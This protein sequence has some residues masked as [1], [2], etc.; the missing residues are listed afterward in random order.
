MFMTLVQTIMAV[1]FNNFFFLVVPC[2]NVWDSKPRFKFLLL[3]HYI[4]R[5]NHF[6]NKKKIVVRKKPL[7]IFITA[8]SSSTNLI[9]YEIIMIFYFMTILYAVCNFMA[10]YYT[11]RQI[12]PYGLLWWFLM[13]NLWRE[14]NTGRKYIT[15]DLPFGHLFTNK[16]LK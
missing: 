11:E 10:W 6:K 1:L 7:C 12:F 5:C 4:Y 3:N 14:A 2:G 13:D 8:N 16:W 15:R 9:I